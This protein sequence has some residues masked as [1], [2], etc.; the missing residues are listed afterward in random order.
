MNDRPYRE[1]LIFVA[2]TTLQII[3][4]TFYERL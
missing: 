3:T 4:E 2:G 1:I